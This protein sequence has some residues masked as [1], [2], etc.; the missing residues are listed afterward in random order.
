MVLQIL[1]QG[2]IFQYNVTDAVEM[3]QVTPRLRQLVAGLAPRR[4]GFNPNITESNTR[5]HS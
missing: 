3:L 2:Y 4:T 1:L 5:L